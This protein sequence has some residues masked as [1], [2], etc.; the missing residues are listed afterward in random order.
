MGDNLGEEL[1]C[2]CLYMLTNIQ[3]LVT[4]KYVLLTDDKNAIR[5]LGQVKQNVAKNLTQK[6]LTAHTSANLCWQMKKSGNIM[7]VEEVLA[8]LQGE[9]ESERITTYC[10]DRYSLFPEMQSMTCEEMADKIMREE[11]VVYMQ[12]V[13]YHNGQP[14]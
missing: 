12:I 11:I 4:Y 6:Y 5:L 3:E 7:R 9:K 14:V 2:V 10:S 1:L 13:F 8:I